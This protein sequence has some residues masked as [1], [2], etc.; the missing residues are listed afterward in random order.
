[1]QVNPIPIPRKKRLSVR[2]KVCV[3]GLNCFGLHLY[4]KEFAAVVN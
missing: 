3:V 1:V 4:D 2:R